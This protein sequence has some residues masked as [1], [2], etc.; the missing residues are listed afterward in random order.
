M[1]DTAVVTAT[2]RC[3]V[4]GASAFRTGVLG[5]LAQCELCGHI[6]YPAQSTVSAAELYGN[7]YFTGAEYLDYSS[8]QGTLAKN[9]RR[10]LRLMRRYGAA[11]GRLLEVGCAYGFFLQEAREAFRVEGIDVA[12]EAVAFAAEQLQV[13]ARKLEF[14]TLQAEEPYDVV[15]LWD[16]LE[17]LA[18][19]DVYIAKASEVVREGGHLFLTTVDIGS[20]LARVQGRRWRQIHPPTHL[21]YFSRATMRRL[22]ERSGFEV[23]GITAVGT[24]RE[25]TNMLRGLS[26]FGKSRVVRQLAEQM[27]EKTGRMWGHTSVYLNLGD[28][29]FVAAR[30]RR[31]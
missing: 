25:I 28:N 4:C 13:P 23:L 30:R 26:L 1:P 5:T 15:C 20:Y 27:L 8:Q 29:M 16:T 19:P 31:P 9:F 17:H 11:G 21:H 22:L 14:P 24:H 10:Y 6:C 3:V 2:K 12:A 18:E 7:D